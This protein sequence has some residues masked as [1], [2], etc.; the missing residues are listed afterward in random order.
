ML[1]SGYVLGDGRHEFVEQASLDDEY[2]LLGTQDFFLI[3]L[4]FLCDVALGVDERLFAYPFCGNFVLV[5]VAHLDVVAKHVVVGNLQARNTG[6]IAQC[7]LHG[8]QIVLAA[9]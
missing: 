8:H 3:F 9:A 5:G 6:L 1:D 4:E 2:L 7:A